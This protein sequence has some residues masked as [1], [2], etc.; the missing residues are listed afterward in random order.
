MRRARNIIV[1]KGCKK[2]VYVQKKPYLCG[3]QERAHLIITNLKT[4]TEM[5]KDIRAMKITE[6]GL[7]YFPN[8]TPRH[9]RR[10]IRE[11]IRDTTV[12]RKI[13]G[14]INYEENTRLLTPKMVMI[15]YQYLGKP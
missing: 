9:A 15:V 14:E 8:V 1:I 12:L 6:L 10:R 3:A 13:L 4:Y 2:F 11:L 7:L 5:S